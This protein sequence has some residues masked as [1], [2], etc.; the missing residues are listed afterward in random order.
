MHEWADVER[1]VRA[2]FSPEQVAH[3]LALEGGLPISHETVYRHIYADKKN[4]GDLHQH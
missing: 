1:L 2:D 3:R 4:G